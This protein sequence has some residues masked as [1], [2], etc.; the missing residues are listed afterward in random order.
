MF[1]YKSRVEWLN[2]AIR[3]GKDAVFRLQDHG[4]AGVNQFLLRECLRLYRVHKLK[5][6]QGIDL[7]GCEAAVYPHRQTQHGRQLVGK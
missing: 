1:A 7:L 5:R 6:E 4:Q 2:G 3:L